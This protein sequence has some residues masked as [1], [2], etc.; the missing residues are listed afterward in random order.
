MKSMADLFECITEE[1]GK[2]GEFFN[3]DVDDKTKDKIKDVNKAWG[4]LDF[5]ILNSM[6]TCGVNYENTDFDK[7]YLF[8]ANFSYPRD[9][10]QVSYRPRHIESGIINIC[11]MGRMTPNNTWEN[12][13]NKMDCAVYAK[14]THDILLEKKSPIRKTLE[15]FCQKAHYTQK[16]NKEEMS[17]NLKNTIDNMFKKYDNT[18]SYKKIEAIDGEV[19]EELQNLVFAGEATMLDKFK[20]QK[21]H[22]QNKFID[23]VEETKLETA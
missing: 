17:A 7:E 4:D 14:M 1:T 8:V 20:L 9:V 15:L 13:S 18:I 6:I 12:D 22:F 16:I 23:D 2:K 11:F 21:Y 10:I 19:E 3:A 5:V